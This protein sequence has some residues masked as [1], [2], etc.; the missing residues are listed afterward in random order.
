MNRDESDLQVLLHERADGAAFEPVDAGSIIRRAQ[1]QRRRRQVRM[2]TALAGLVT[3][4]VIAVVVIEAPAPERPASLI[5]ATSPLELTPSASPTLKL[6]TPPLA[7]L[8]KGWIAAPPGPL[9]VQETSGV[10]VGSKIVYWGGGNGLDTAPSFSSNGAVFDVTRRQWSATSASPLAGRG[11]MA[12]AGSGS[13]FFVWGG[14]TG[15]RYFSDGAVY[16]PATNSWKKIATGPLSGQE[17]IGAVWSGSEFIVLTAPGAHSP[18]QV[19]A[20]NPTTNSW[21][22]LPDLPTHPATATLLL[23]TGRVVVFGADT[24]YV[25]SPDT[26]AWSVIASPVN[27]SPAT[28]SFATEGEYAYA[29][30]TLAVRTAPVSTPLSFQRFSFAAGVWDVR[31]APPL[32]EMECYPRLA[33]STKEVFLDYCGGNAFFNRA[34]QFW[35]AGSD[36]G[37]G[38]PVAVGPEFVFYYPGEA[39]TVIDTGP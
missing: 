14:S 35:S 4:S 19:A 24:S 3:A 34:G 39:R 9:P 25:L 33:M 29:V 12:M 7:A 36:A 17:T 18:N 20:Y 31:P 37:I 13:L 6:P 21:R 32:S 27:I 15:H 5:P 26:A 2:G 30:G 22:R 10:R 28:I 16:N 38:L 8:P 11:Y 23:V 1:G